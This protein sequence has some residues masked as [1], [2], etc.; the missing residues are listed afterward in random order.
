[1]ISRL[2]DLPEDHD[3][4]ICNGCGDLYVFKY[5]EDDGYCGDCRRPGKPG[6]PNAEAVRTWKEEIA[7]RAKR[8]R[9]SRSKK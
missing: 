5:G 6:R 4:G 3:E 9:K 2:E 8:R 1:M 7:Q